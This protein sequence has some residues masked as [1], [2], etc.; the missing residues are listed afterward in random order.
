MELEFQQFRVVTPQEGKKITHA[1]TC[2]GLTPVGAMVG[3]GMA[4]WLPQC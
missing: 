4:M 1:T 3:I 2:C